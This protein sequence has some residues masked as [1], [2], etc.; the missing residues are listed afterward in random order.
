MEC[1]RERERAAARLHCVNCQPQKCAKKEPKNHLF[2]GGGGGGG[3]RQRGD[4][5]GS[6][7]GC[8]LSTLPTVAIVVADFN[9]KCSCCCKS[10]FAAL[11]PLYP[12]YPPPST[13]PLCLLC[14]QIC[15]AHRY[16]WVTPAHP[17]LPLSA[18]RELVL[19][20]GFRVFLSLSLST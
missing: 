19:L 5:T 9:L 16:D 14:L 18:R 12:L 3:E 2:T 4:S 7:A 15:L 6:A 20:F 17:S 10:L 8:D 13:P 1:G 11:N